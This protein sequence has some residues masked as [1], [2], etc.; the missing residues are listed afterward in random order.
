MYSSE[1]VFLYFGGK[2]V[3]VWFLDHRIVLF[4]IFLRNF[5]TVFHNCCT[6]LHSH[7][8]CKKVPFPPYPHQH[9]LLLGLFILDRCE[10][11][12]Q[13]GFDLHFT[14]DEWCWAS[15]YVSVGHLYVFFG[16][17]SVHVFCPCWASFYV[18]VGHL[19]VFF[20]EMSVHVFCPVSFGLFVFWVLSC[21]SS[22]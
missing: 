19:Y 15:F 11:I 10:V 8:Q 2:Y 13:C 12:S 18:S 9:L 1:L 5:H 3:V 4:L 14:D 6:N 16:E 22:L 20:G 21:I 17:M 7:Q